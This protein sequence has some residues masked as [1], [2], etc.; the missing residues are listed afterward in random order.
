[1]PAVLSKDLPLSKF[2]KVMDIMNKNEGLQL[3][4]SYLAGTNNEAMVPFNAV[5]NVSSCNPELRN[6]L[7]P[8][9]KAL[10]DAKI[11]I[12][13]RVLKKKTATNTRHIRFLST[14]IRT[15]DNDLTEVDGKVDSHT[16][17]FGEVDVRARQTE[18]SVEDLRTT[19]D[20][21]DEAAARDVANLREEVQNNGHLTTGHEHRLMSTGDLA[22]N[23]ISALNYGGCSR[24]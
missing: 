10:K 15:V 21:N 13:V 9:T 11:P 1:M 22:V 20:L 24:D 4:G 18:E 5:L 19:M 7:S 8:G 6:L 12:A 16:E 17:R 3:W 14:S 23:K 2:A